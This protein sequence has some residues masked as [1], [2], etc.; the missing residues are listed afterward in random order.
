MSR[1][2]DEIRRIR[3]ANRDIA[4]LACHIADLRLDAFTPDRAHEHQNWVRQQRLWAEDRLRT[5]HQRID[6]RKRH[7]KRFTGHAR[8]IVNQV[9]IEREHQLEMQVRIV[10]QI[11]DT[12][13]WRM[14]RA[15]ARLLAALYAERTHHLPLGTG[16]GGPLLV[17]RKPRESGDFYVIENDLTRVLGQGDLTAVWAKREWTRPLYLE[18]K[19]R[20]VWEEYDTAE[21]GVSAIEIDSPVDREMYADFCRIAGL[22]DPPPDVVMRHDERQEQ[23]MLAGGEIMLRVTEHRAPDLPAASGHV[24][25]TIGN[26]LTRALRDGSSYDL[27]ER[28]LGVAAV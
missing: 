2:A 12:I 18:V 6:L 4:G 20:G 9:L 8:G 21:L 5:L 24:W 15:D 25:R 16:I 19:T 17:A 13:A 10:Q 11:G 22:K 26:V 14:L 3:E 23:G 7:L 27:I 1:L 28:G